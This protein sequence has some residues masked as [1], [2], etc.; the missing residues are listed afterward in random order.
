M[1]L[2]FFDHGRDMMLRND[3]LATLMQQDAAAARA[4][5]QAYADV[6]ACR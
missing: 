6:R 5:L 1:Q 4:F 2:N 3:V